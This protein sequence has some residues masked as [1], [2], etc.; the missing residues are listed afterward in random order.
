MTKW[1]SAR[2]FAAALRPHLVLEHQAGHT[3]ALERAHRVMNVD[4]IAV[5]GVGVGEQQQIRAQRDRARG[6]DVFFQAHQP[7]V[8]LAKPRLADS[9]AGDEGGGVTHFRDQPRAEAVEHAG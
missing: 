8:G 3:R 6:G 9:A 5:P 2:A 4:R 7:H 1:G